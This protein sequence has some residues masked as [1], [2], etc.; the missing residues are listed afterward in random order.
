LRSSFISW[1]DVRHPAKLGEAVLG[2]GS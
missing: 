2:N 1:C